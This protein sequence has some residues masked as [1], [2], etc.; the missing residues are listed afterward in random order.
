MAFGN[1]LQKNQFSTFRNIWALKYNYIVSSQHLKE[2]V[3]NI[4]SFFFFTFKHYFRKFEFTANNFFATK[5]NLH[6]TTVHN[7]RSAKSASLP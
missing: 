3:L 2:M 1:V 7:V 6:Q 4:F 5:S